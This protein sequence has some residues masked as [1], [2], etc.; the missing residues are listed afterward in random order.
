[1]RLDVLEQAKNKIVLHI[2]VEDHT[3]CNALRDELNNDVNVTAAA[4]RIEHPLKP[5]PRFVVEVKSGDPKKAILDASN[6]LKK[7]FESLG[8]NL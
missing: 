8:K 7:Q 3:F 4:Y 6:R 1:M 5:I 2:H